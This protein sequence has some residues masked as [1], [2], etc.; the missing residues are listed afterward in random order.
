MLYEIR[1][2]EPLIFS[3]AG[4]LHQ[5]QLQAKKGLLYTAFQS[6]FI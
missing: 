6:V 1:Q 5:L 3:D 2:R 4:S